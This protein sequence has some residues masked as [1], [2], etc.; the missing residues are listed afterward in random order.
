MTQDQFE[1]MKGLIVEVE[2]KACVYGRACERY[3]TYEGYDS[4]LLALER[5]RNKTHADWGV[6][7]KALHE[8]METLKESK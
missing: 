5:Y 7:S 3:D 8:F 6:A 1:K 2:I 4:N